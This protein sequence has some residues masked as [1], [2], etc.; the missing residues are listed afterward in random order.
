MPV[1]TSRNVHGAPDGVGELWPREGT[2]ERGIER[3][4]PIGP[5]L[6]TSGDL[7]L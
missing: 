1:R 6:T 4:K 2:K 7:A 3:L 5:A